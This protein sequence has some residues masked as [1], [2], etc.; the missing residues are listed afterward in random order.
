MS[1]PRQFLRFLAVGLLNTAFGYGVFAGLILL[2]VPP[3]PAL[4]VAYVLG[5]SFNFVTT[6]RL[7]FNR[8]GYGSLG[9]F[10]LAYVVI[11]FFNLALYQLLA[12]MGASPLLAQALCL[13]P[14]AVFSFLLFK[15]QVFRE[16]R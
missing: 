3:I 15:F 10:I 13:P 6:R 8:T 14:V 5:V 4:V 12:T 16:G 11:Y 2:G 9:R 1:T 7:V